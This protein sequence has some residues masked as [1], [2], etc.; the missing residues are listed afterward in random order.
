MIRYI[1]EHKDQIGAE[2]SCRVLRPAVR[3]FISCRG[4]RAAKDS[5]PPA[6]VSKD[7][8]LVPEIA[9]LHAEKASTGCGGCTL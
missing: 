9:R 6:R 7:E 3:G 2:A 1:D 5:P 8:L 4:Y